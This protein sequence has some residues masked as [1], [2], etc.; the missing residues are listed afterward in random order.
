MPGMPYFIQKGTTYSVYEDFLALPKRRIAFLDDMRDLNLPRWKVRAATSS[1]I[2]GGP[3]DKEEHARYD[4]FG[5]P[6]FDQLARVWELPLGQPPYGTTG[7]WPRWHG[8]AEGIMRE[9][10]IRA[11]EV[12]LGI[13]HQ[14]AAATSPALKNNPSPD[15]ETRQASV[16][17]APRTNSELKKLKHI[18]PLG[19][20]RFWPIEV[21]WACGSPTFQGWVT[22]QKHGR[23]PHEGHV[24]V[25]LATPAP[26]RGPKYT[27]QNILTNPEPVPYPTTPEYKA[28]GGGANSLGAVIQDV[29]ADAGMW[30]IGAKSTKVERV[31]TTEDVEIDIGTLAITVPWPF[32]FQ[33]YKA[34][35]TEIVVV[36]PAEADGGVLGNPTGYQP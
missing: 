27:A 9:T 7:W 21:I 1:T 16:T 19:T 33:Y 31:V 24:N 35:S 32:P 13:T 29:N 30:V 12:S 8:P 22:W 11:I 17:P 18:L 20:S 4:W 26:G 5:D 6:Q 28:S 25:I 34:Q 23:R 2:P 14:P 3:D 10:F 15:P 36:R